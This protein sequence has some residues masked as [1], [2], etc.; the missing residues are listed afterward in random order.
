MKAMTEGNTSIFNIPV[1]GEAA[2]KDMLHDFDTLEI[3]YAVLPDLNVGDGA[4][5]VAVAN[6]DANLL[7]AWFAMYQQQQ[8]LA[9]NEVPEMEQLNEGSYVETGT[10]DAQEYIDHS[11][12]KYQEANAEYEAQSQ[13]VVQKNP[14]KDGNCEEYLRLSQDTRYSKITMDRRT[15]VDVIP[16]ETAKK[17]DAMGY[18]CARIPGYYG[19]N[20]KELMIP[21]DQVF[22]LREGQTYT[23]FVPHNGTIKVFDAASGQVEEWDHDQ[24][25]HNFDKIQRSLYKVQNIMNRPEPPELSRTPEPSLPPLPKGPKV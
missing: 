8:M 19:E 21:K 22:V 25:M 18:F 9:G 7:K 4:T 20:E 13:E 16:P 23:S 3:N 2:V 24:I 17:I 12:P 14:M 10:M 5:Q 15:L 11:D 6:A 1:E